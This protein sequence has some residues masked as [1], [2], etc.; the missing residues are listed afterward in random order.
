M[1]PRRNCEQTESSASAKEFPGPFS[2]IKAELSLEN[3]DV[4]QQTTAELCDLRCKAVM[5]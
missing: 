4:K 1:R 3:I 5:L 2:K